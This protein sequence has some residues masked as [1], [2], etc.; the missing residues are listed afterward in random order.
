MIK[1]YNYNKINR[2]KGVGNMKKKLIIAVSVIVAIMLLFGLPAI[3]VSGADT[4]IS[5]SFSGN[6][7]S[8]RGFAGGTITLRSGTAGTYKLYWADN[9]NVLSGFDPICTLTVS[10]SGSASFDMT[11]FTAIPPQATKVAAFKSG[12]SAAAVSSADAVY[13][14]PENKLLKRSKG[15]MLYSFA[16]YSDTHISSNEEGSSTKYPYDEQK[17]ADAFNA[18]ADRGVDFIVTTGDNVNNQRADNKGAS[19]PFYPEEWN[20]Y[21]KILANSNYVNPVY[22]AIGNHELWCYDNADNGANLIN[23]MDWKTGSDYFRTVTGLDSTTAAMNTGK[24]YYEVTEPVTGDHFLFMALEGGFYTNR[25]NEFTDEQLD[26]LDKK[27]TAYENDGKNIFVLEHC[28]IKQWGAGDQLD[29][30]IYDLGL[31][32]SNT[33]TAK[34]KALMQKHKSVVMITGHTHFKLD[35][36]LNYSTN[37]ATSATTIH[38]SSV[39][40]VRNILNRTTRVDDTSRELSEGYFVEVYDNATIFYGANLYYNKI[41]P[42]TSYIIP[43]TTSAIEPKPTEAPTQA[44]TVA[45]TAAPTA[46]P[47]SAPTQAPTV[48]PTQAPEPDI[49]YGDADSD[50]AVTIMDVT[51]IQRSLL[52]MW[53]LDD[54]AMKRSIVSGENELTIVDATLIQ[55]YLIGLLDR[56]PVE[57]PA[58]LSVGARAPLITGNADLAQTGA[59]L[60]S[61][62]SQAKAALDKYWLLASYDQ[63]QALKKA[64]KLNCTYDELNTAYSRF[65]TAVSDFYTGDKVDVYFSNNVGWSSVY[66]YCSQGHGKDKNASWPG[67]KM[68]YVTTNKYGEKIYKITLPTAKYN[69]IIF[70]NNSGAQTVDLP[71]GIT[72]NQGFYYNSTLGKDGQG[73]LKCSSYT[74]K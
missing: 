74:Y 46:A 12:N 62:R 54:S 16:S 65:N 24:A 23:G 35:L 29:N 50:N 17:L 30:P 5:Y 6:N 19:N 33:A 38:N 3:T 18:A 71:L 70:T 14:L 43:Q 13:T 28:N 72:R 15:D 53:Q 44:P 51:V 58:A 52:G 1:M 9:N 10:S 4:A 56:F 27:I 37:N 45:P 8:D 31:Q 2:D 55:R 66:A 48:A 22:E 7:A 11:E 57:G 25:V 26:W 73:H 42:S 49:I 61:L 63:Y 59:D 36:Q 34:L 60:N 20:T 39:G 68:E 32:T 41:N 47:T 64:Y 67:E 21:L 69:F 40:G